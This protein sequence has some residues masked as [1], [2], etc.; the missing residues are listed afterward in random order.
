LEDI[1]KGLF[2]ELDNGTYKTLRQIGVKVREL[3]GISISLRNL[4]TFLKRNGYRKLQCASL[5]AKA[6]PAKQRSFYRDVLVWLMHAAQC[7]EL[8]LLFMDA[9]HFVFGTPTPGAIY[10][11]A[12]RSIK[13]FSGRM[14]HNVL[15]ALDFVTK[16]V[17]TVEN[18]TYITA[19][20]VIMMLETLAKRDA[21]IPISI[22]LDNARYQHC[23]DV[24]AC[25]AR[26]GISLVFLPPYSPNLNLI[27]RYWK[28]IKG[29]VLD[30]AYH[31]SFGEFK[32]AI[33]QGIA[34]AAG[35]NRPLLDN[36]IN[37]KVQLY[38]DFGRHL[39]F[40][41]FLSYNSA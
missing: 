26:L 29:E 25:A 4:S 22:V 10:S 24:T 13:T 19:S 27:E 34:D 35:T 30:A 1:K 11:K 16:E 28:F 17:V 41:N 23:K 20:E 3:F 12:R 32:N 15:A 14:R 40:D 9:S 8:V 33:P 38:D 31:R 37:Y 7:N 2:N 6:D 36:L 5:P 18:D 21:G 39:P